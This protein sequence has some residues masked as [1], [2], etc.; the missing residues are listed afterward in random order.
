MLNNEAMTSHVL[1]AAHALQVH[2]PALAIRRIGE[3][4]V[5][6]AGGES[7]ARECRAEFHVFSSSLLTHEQ[8]VGLAYSVSFGI[9][10]LAEPS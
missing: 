4:E 2:L 9:E 8:Q 10:L 6:F 3:H 5:K 7:V 1:L